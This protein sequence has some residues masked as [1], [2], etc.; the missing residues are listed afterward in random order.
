M[1]VVRTL[2]ACTSHRRRESFAESRI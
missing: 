1:C 2:R